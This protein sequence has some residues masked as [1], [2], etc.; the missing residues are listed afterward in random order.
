MELKGLTIAHRGIHD[1]NVPE[2]SMEAFRLALDKNVSIELDVRLLKDGNVVVFHDLNTKRMTGV[3][4]LIEDMT[5]EEVKKLH[6]LHTNQKIPLLIEVLEL[7][8]SKVPIVIETKNVKVGPLE[9]AL[10]KI[11]DGYSNFCIQSFLI[12]TIFWFRLHRPKYIVGLLVSSGKKNRYNL[13]I[14][15]HFI[16]HS[17]RNI[18][19]QTISKI[20]KRG[21]PIFVWTIQ[22]EIELIKAKRYGDSYIINMKP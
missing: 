2:N 15:V 14:P 20:R 5:L 1:R 9:K 10:T 16:S 22:N 21:I 6:L 13:W 3:N 19:N 7:I 8:N 18:Q 12:K 17:L 4:R 11:L